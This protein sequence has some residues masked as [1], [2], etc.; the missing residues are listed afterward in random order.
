MFRGSVPAAVRSHIVTAVQSW[1]SPSVYVACSGNLTVERCIASVRKDVP[2]HG[3]DVLLY[4][5]AIG[6]WLT[7]GDLGYTLKQEYADAYPWLAD[8]MGQDPTTRLAGLLQAS[9][10]A[11]FALRDG[12]YFLRQMDGYERQWASIL[13]KT[14]DKLA[15]VTMRLESFTPED[16]ATWIDRVPPEAAMASYPP[17]TGAATAF[18]SDFRALERMFEWEKPEFGLLEGESLTALFD[19][20]RDRREWLL[21]INQR[22]DGM[23]DHLR[24]MART[25]NRGLPVYVY[26]SDETRTLVGPAQSL[27]RVTMPR[28]GPGDRLGDTM[29]L[30]PLTDGQFH[31]LRSQYMNHHIRPGSAEI[32]VAVAVD[33]V[34]VGVFAANRPRAYVGP[35]RAYLL[36]DFPV[37]PNDYARLAKLVLYAALS[38]EAEV[39]FTRMSNHPIHHLLTTAFTRKPVSMKYRGLFHLHSRKR[40]DLSKE[41]WGKGIREDDPYYGQDWM[42]NYASE[43]GRWTLAEGLAEWKERHG[44]LREEAA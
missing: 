19:K 40:L 41:S 1:T 31:A 20:I 2:I 37:A 14:R 7:G 29:T 28:L 38:K 8:T 23:E 27:D 30:H 33:G 34:L 4:S 32:A 43:T 18:E 12:R 11:P 13:G 3:N 9:R 25:T 42:L 6:T 16:A 15:G 5:S 10:F 35:D 39:L 36:S 21:G 17:F 24:G 22:L 26:G 44:I